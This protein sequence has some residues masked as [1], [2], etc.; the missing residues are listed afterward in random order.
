LGTTSFECFNVLRY[1]EYAILAVGSVVN[2]FDVVV[3]RSKEVFANICTGGL[4]TAW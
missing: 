3:V 1:I 4:E 2:N